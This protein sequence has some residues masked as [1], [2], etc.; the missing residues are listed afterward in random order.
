MPPAQTRCFSSFRESRV[1]ACSQ[2]SG[3]RTTS[4]AGANESPGSGDRLRSP[5]ERGSGGR[6][7]ASSPG[8]D[9]R[10]HAPKGAGPV[11]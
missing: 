11:R 4:T 2:G 7:R 10:S 3:R 8:P 9:A 5:A 6:G 1:S